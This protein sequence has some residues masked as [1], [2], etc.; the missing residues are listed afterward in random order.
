MSSSE[1]TI[2]QLNRFLWPRKLT[3]QFSTLSRSQAFQNWTTI[4]NAS[5][6]RQNSISGLLVSSHL[7][8]STCSPWSALNC[9][10]GRP[11][12]SFWTNFFPEGRLLCREKQ[13]I[14][15]RTIFLVN[16][17][18]PIVRLELWRPN[19]AYVHMLVNNWSCHDASYM[20]CRL[21]GPDSREYLTYPGVHF[22]NAYNKVPGLSTTIYHT[23]WR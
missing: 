17:D 1:L 21:C 9:S 13:C 14:T 2:K 19:I 5:D 3:D 18:P 23:F 8:G 12:A 4:R 6:N 10:I 7:G 11:H 20:F 16:H 15:M 22:G